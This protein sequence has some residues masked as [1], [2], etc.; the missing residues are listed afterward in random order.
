[1]D[2]EQEFYAAFSTA[3][4]Q[5]KTV[6][7]SLISFPVRIHRD[8]LPPPLR[9]WKEMM[10]HP[11]R[12]GF[13]AAAHIEYQGLQ[14]KG[15][16]DEIERTQ[17]RTI[18]LPL[19]WVWTYKFDTNGFLTKYK[20][21]IC[22]RGDLQMTEKDN[23][24]ATLAIRTFRALMAL[25]AAFDLEIIQ[26]DAIN[27]FLNSEIDEETTTE[28]PEGFKTSGKVL[29]LRKAL[30]GLKQ[31]PQLWYNY[32]TKTLK[33]LGLQEV[34]GTNCVLTNDSIILFYF[35]D[36]IMLLHRPENR[37]QAERL[38][39]QLKEQCDIRVLPNANWFLGI[40]IVR[41]RATRRL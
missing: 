23:Y 37:P 5:T 4:F 2:I 18:P 13:L 10:K 24:A 12:E 17:L 19:L 20:A 14:N 33:Q 32:L 22:V 8:S 36:D 6:E 9:T 3:L 25:V 34:Q 29:L 11:H 26:I 35:V 41:E 16:F 1:M 30:Y 39:N 40:R 21:R 7:C 38:I 28:C 27:A 31:A 15:T